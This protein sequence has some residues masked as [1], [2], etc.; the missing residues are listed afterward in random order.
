VKN[1]GEP[2]AGEPL[3][4]IDAAAGGNQR[5]SGFHSRAAW[6]PPADPTHRRPVSSTKTASGHGSGS[7]RY[8]SATRVGSQSASARYRISYRTRLVRLRSIDPGS[9]SPQP[10]SRKLVGWPAGAFASDSRPP[11]RSSGGDV[12]PAPSGRGGN[13]LPAHRPGPGQQ[14]RGMARDRKGIGADQRSPR[15]RGM[16]AHGRRNAHADRNDPCPCGSGR[17]LKTLLRQIT[18]QLGVNS[19]LNGETPD[20]LEVSIYKPF[21]GAGAG[22]EPAPRG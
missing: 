18:G 5:Q 10:T 13:N 14:S 11:G 15:A 4:R 20:R 6:A 19:P 7:H 2:C 3:A 17:K 1:V 12:R 21:L 16:P 22:F 9:H 8:R